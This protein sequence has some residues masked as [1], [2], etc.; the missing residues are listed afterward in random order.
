MHNFNLKYVFFLIFYSFSFFFHNIYFI[1]YNREIIDIDNEFKDDFFE[2]DNKYIDDSVKIKPIALYYPECNNFSY[3]K[4]FNK[5]LTKDNIN[6][7]EIYKLV[8]EQI[9]L[10]KAHEIYGFGIFYNLFDFNLI[11]RFTIDIFFKKKLF[12]CFLIWRNDEIVDLNIDIITILINN[13]SKYL[14]SENYIKI[15]GM[16][17]LSINN[18]VIIKKRFKIIRTLRILSKKIIGKLFLLY[19]FIG[20]YSKPIFIKQFDAAYDF[21]KIDLLHEKITKKNILYYSGFIYKNLILNKIDLKFKLFRTIYVNSYNFPDYKPEKLYIQNK[22]ILQSEIHKYKLDYEFL[23]VDSWNDHFN[24]NYLEFDEKFGY[25]SINA[26]SKSILNLSYISNNFK[27]NYNNINKIDIAIH[28]HI[29]YEDLFPKILRRI[30][31]IPFKYDLFISTV[32][33]EKKLAIEKLLLNSNHNIYEIKIFKNIGRDIYPF[34]TQMKNHFK[35][36]KY[37]CHLHTKK[38]VHKRLLGSNWSEYLYNNLIGTKEIISNIICNFEYYAKIGFIFPEPYYEIIKDVNYFDNINFPLHK[39]NKKF[40]N[41]IL[42]KNFHKYIGEKIIFPVGNMFWAKIKAIYQ[43]FNI[44]LKYPNEL[45]QTNATIMHAIERLWLYLVKL[46]G[47]DY[48]II[49]WHY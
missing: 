21:S 11:S 37:I 48:K 31:L 10:A 5:D 28:I 43:I 6:K 17:I 18:P 1:I 30:N 9:K 14:I 33:E 2:K 13:I 34:L 45:N 3:S 23:F 46:N 24:G 22:I 7:Y 32:T 40:I 25:S 38:S 47:Y 42:K 36:Y 12:P 8:K 19:P 41:C 15:K 16:P 4:Y 29:F 26:F 49:F 39:P 27:L 20:N 44:R 35:H